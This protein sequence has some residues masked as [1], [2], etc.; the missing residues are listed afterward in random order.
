V[1]TVKQNSE[2]FSYLYF[3]ADRNGNNYYAT[4]YADHLALVEQVR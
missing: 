4:N 3:V 2:I 1:L